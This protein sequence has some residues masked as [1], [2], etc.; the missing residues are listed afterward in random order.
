[1][2][3]IDDAAI[4]TDRIADISYCTVCACIQTQHKLELDKRDGKIN[5]R[6]TVP[7]PQQ[8]MSRY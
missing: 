6:E 8:E 1:M 4:V 5:P 7:P 3:F 2:P